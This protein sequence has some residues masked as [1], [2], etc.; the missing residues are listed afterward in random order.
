MTEQAAEGEL[1][2]FVKRYRKLM[3]CY[4]SDELPE[5]YR[6]EKSLRKKD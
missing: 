4:F 1:E 2:Q 6:R 3:H 5:M